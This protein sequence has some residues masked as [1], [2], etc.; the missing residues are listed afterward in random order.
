MNKLYDEEIYAIL[1]KYGHKEPHF[2]LI[3]ELSNYVS[4]KQ[5]EGYES[6]YT[7]ANND[8]AFK[9]DKNIVEALKKQEVKNDYRIINA[10]TDVPY[11]DPEK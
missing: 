9:A 8:W 1:G 6:G 3:T 10:N 5:E 11:G 7:H 2:N 4:K